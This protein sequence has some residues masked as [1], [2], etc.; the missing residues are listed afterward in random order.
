[1]DM[2]TSPLSTLNDATLLKTDAFVN[3]VWVAGRG[4]FPVEDPATGAAS[5]P[6]GAYLLQHNAV[7]AHNASRLVNLQ[8]VRMGRPGR[9]YISPSSR[10]GVLEKVR[11]GGEAVVVGEGTVLESVQRYLGLRTAGGE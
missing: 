3:G 7:S 4:R 2:K 10:A 8:G 5:G 9:I 11:V 1:M 6:L